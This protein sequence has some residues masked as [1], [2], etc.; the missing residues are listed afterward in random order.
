ML[1][2]NLREHFW[3]TDV[4]TVVTAVLDRPDAYYDESKIE[5]NQSFQ[6]LFDLSATTAYLPQP[7]FDDLSL[8]QSAILDMLN[9]VT[10]LLMWMVYF[11]CEG[12]YRFPELRML[13]FA[14][15]DRN[16]FVHGRTRCLQLYTSYSKI[17]GYN[18]KLKL[19]D[20]K[21]S[22]H[23]FYYI[24]VLRPLQVWLLGESYDRITS[25]IF[26]EKIY[27]DE[28]IPL[29]IDGGGELT[30]Q[31]ISQNVLR[32]FLFV[33]TERG[34]L[35]LDRMFYSMLKRYPE[36]IPEKLQLSFREMRHGMVAL[37]REY[38]HS[39]ID[40]AF[41]DVKERQAGHAARTGREVYAVDK[42]SLASALGTACLLYTSRCV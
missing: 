33:D 40:E 27:E 17:F 20:K 34:C 2:Q 12:P 3:L 31:Q 32:T 9:E 13:K 28:E 38:V 8:Y 6:Q 37:L 42:Y 30:D 15:N 24:M 22:N 10:L 16:V 21:T 5:P 11:S 19:L 26:K 25:D 1:L 4:K 18:P 7:R 36:S 23:V 39:D 35:V 41:D 29:Y 14:G